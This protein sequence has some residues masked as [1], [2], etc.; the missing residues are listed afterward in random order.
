MSTNFCIVTTTYKRPN[1]IL[2]CVKSVQKQINSTWEMLIIIDDTKTNYDL[3]KKVAETDSRLTLLQ[4]LE[5]FGKNTS[6]NRAIDHLCERNFSGYIIF[7]DDDDWL[8]PN[9][10]SDFADI[11][12]SSSHPWLVSQ[13]ISDTTKH[14]FT[15]NNTGRDMIHYQ[16]DSLLKKS[17]LGDATHCIDFTSTK[18]VRFPRLIKNAEEWI[19]FAHLST[20]HSHFKYIP[21]A[22]T[23]SAG[24]AQTGLTHQYHFNN[25]SRKNVLLLFKEIFSRKIFSPFV[26]IYLFGRLTRSLFN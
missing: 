2:R 18:N 3:L 14:S 5:N 7:L 26:Y 12:K 20:I 8:S 23:V 24:Y 21:T 10:L 13:R 9:C 19:Y 11:L 1:E 4:N 22:G 16:Y 17:F 25:E 6:V 15:K